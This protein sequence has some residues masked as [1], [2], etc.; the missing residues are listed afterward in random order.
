MDDANSP[1]HEI[2]LGNLRHIVL[3]YA[4]GSTGNSKVREMHIEV[5]ENQAKLPGSLHM[6][7]QPKASVRSSEVSKRSW[8]III[9]LP[10]DSNV[11]I[12]ARLTNEIL[13]VTG[14]RGLTSLPSSERYFSLQGCRPTTARST[15]SA[16]L[17]KYG[18][19]HIG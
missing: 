8:N 12:V 19:V 9:L 2:D 11:S 7:S 3:Y 17:G 15:I 4:I 16:G 13:V 1:V 10:P 5:E 18:A 14:S 6:S